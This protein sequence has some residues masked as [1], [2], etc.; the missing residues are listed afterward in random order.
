MREY[1]IEILKH[2]NAKL[3][4]ALLDSSVA[5]DDWLHTFAAELCNENAVAESYERI[6][7]RGGTLAYIADVQQNNRKALKSKFFVK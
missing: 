1:Q 5:L 7:E 3:A 4:A 6:H 2:E